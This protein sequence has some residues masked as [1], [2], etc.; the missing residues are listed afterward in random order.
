MAFETPPNEYN[1]DYLNRL[2][3]D[4]DTNLRKINSPANKKIENDPNSVY[5]TSD[6]TIKR[7][8]DKDSTTEDV[9]NVLATLIEDLKNKGVLE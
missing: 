8:L 1:K 6:R 4:L 2:T 5:T 3:R 9:A 7:G